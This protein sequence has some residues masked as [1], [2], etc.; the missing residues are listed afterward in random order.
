[1]RVIATVAAVTASTIL[2]PLAPTLAQAPVAIVEDVQGKPLGVEFMDYV[3]VGQVIRLAPGE[4]IV[5]AYL[6]SCWR[7]AIAGGSIIVGRE[8]SDVR[9]GKVDRSRVSC[10]GAKIDLTRQQ[11]SKAGGMVFREAR[12][13]K[14]NATPEEPA[15]TLHGLSPLVE[16]RGGGTLVIERLD[17]PGERH[18]IKVAPDQLVRGAFYDFAREGRQLT[19]GAIYRARVAERQVLF[20]VDHS[21]Q[22]GNAPILGRLLPLKP[23]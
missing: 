7:E 12:P 11:A 15:L 3:T 16:V 9:D 10:D 19:A 1:M 2:L 13:A 21:A 8:Q 5:L 6:I 22:P 14:R 17:Q 20:R 18:V 23:I 4:S